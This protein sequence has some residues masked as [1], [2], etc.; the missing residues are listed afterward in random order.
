MWSPRV[1][2]GHITMFVLRF[3]QPQNGH[4]HT[5]TSSYVPS[6]SLGLCLV[7]ELELSVNGRSFV[8]RGRGR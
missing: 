4:S 2:L 8:S 1:Q 3:W 6:V 5:S 7:E